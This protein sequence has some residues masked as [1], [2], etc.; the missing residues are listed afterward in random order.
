MYFWYCPKFYITAASSRSRKGLLRPPTTPL[1]YQGSKAG[2]RTVITAF[3]VI[4]EKAG[5]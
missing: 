1:L 3:H 5:G 2:E 4:G